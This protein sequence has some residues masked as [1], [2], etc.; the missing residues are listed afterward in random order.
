MAR[1]NYFEMVHYLLERGA[2]WRKSD[3]EI[4]LWTQEND[5]GNARATQ[6]QIKVK[7]LLM[8]KGVKF[9]AGQIGRGMIGMGIEKIPLPIIPLPSNQA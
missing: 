4:A 7:H 6:W 2:D 1:L 5:I 9:P 8:A 3:G